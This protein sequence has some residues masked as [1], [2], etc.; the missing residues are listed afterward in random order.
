MAL[1]G[2]NQAGNQSTRKALG[3]GL[4]ALMSPTTVKAEGREPERFFAE[5]R[6]PL[7]SF[8]NETTVTLPIGELV[9]NE[10]QPR[11]HF[12]PEELD[13]LADSI[14]STGLLQPIIVRK[15][16]ESTFEIVAGERRWRAAERAGLTEVPVIIRELTESEAFA[17][18]IIEN[19]QRSDLNP[20]EEALAYQRLIEE[21]GSTQTEVA[22]TIGKDRVSIA[23]AIRLLKLPPAIQEHLIAGTLTAGHGRALLM[24]DSAKEQLALGEQALQQKLSVRATEELVA[25]RLQRGDLPSSGGSSKKGTAAKKSVEPNALALEER[26]RRALGTKVRLVL[27]RNGKGEV[28]ISFFSP[29]ELENVLER[30]KA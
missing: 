3:R 18:A 6:A 28:R 17:I 30:L 24:C 15:R 10:R 27:K 13:T 26:L 5:E 8:P 23:N 14:R 9:R 19:V 11:R 12:R 25:E 16:D 21:F 1:K 22:K 29:G 7:P 4:A 20:I 2:A